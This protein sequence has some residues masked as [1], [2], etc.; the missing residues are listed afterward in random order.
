MRA[1]SL[2]TA[3][4]VS[5]MAVSGGA[6]AAKKKAEAKP[7]AA[8]SAPAEKGGTIAGQVK[9]EGTPPTPAIQKRTSDP[10]CAR[11]AAEAPDPSLMVNNGGIQNAVIRLTNATAPAG[12]KAPS[13]PVVVDQR[14]C[15]YEPHVQVARDGQE[16]KIL[17]SDNTLHNVHAYNGTKGVF[18]Q[19][20]PPKAPPIEKTG[21][22]NGDVMKMKCDVHPWMTGYVVFSKSPY[23]A[24]T[25]K[26]GKF[27]IKG[28]PAG[29]Y[30]VEA[31]QE[32]LGTK[33]TQVTVADGKTADANFA[34]SSK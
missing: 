11:T 15:A 32:K 7:A 21:L 12:E 14:G 31:W 29:T 22:P 5:V 25:D 13:E 3:A 19:A 10:V 20:Q 2:L 26:D 33:T 18:N 17:N 6:L 8:K 9:F 24:V 28:V 34:F 23:Y 30:T 16:V 1:Q 27:S 4:V